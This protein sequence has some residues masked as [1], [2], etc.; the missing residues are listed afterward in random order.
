MIMGAGD[1]AILRLRFFEQTEEEKGTMA[2]IKLRGRKIPLLYTVYE[3]K[4]VQEEICPLGEFQYVIFG[5]NPDDP[6]DVSHY[7]S[8]EHLGA[9]S[10]FIRI[11]GNA[12]LEES[13]ENP[14]LTDKWVM[15]A[16]RP[17]MIPDLI[18]ACAEALSEGMASEY[19]E[20]KTEGP[21]DVTLEDM[22]KKKEKEG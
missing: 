12:G 6:E 2:E 9:L 11:M 22:Q 4:Q 3:M 16:V 20:E 13:G 8:A 17:A 19:P 18:S 7:G 21:V 5:R 14:D 15:R 10:R 1:S